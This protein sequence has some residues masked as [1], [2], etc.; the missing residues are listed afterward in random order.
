MITTGLSY[1]AAIAALKKDGFS[2]FFNPNPPHWGGV[3]YEKQMPDGLWYH[4][5]VGYP[6]STKWINARS[7]GPYPVSVFDPAKAP[8]WVTIHCHGTDPSGFTHFVDFFTRL[9][10]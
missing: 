5:T 3:D 1:D 7:G 4:A 2:Y 9:F 10:K 6:Y 8:P